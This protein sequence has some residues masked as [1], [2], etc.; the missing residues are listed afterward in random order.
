MAFQSVK[1]FKD[2]LPPES[3]AMTSL[4]LAARDVLR[5]FGYR[6]IRIPTLE[7]RELFVKS[8]GETT[9]IVEK[10]M[11]QLEDAGGRHLVLRPEG[12]AGV[13][14]AYLEHSLSQ[15]G[16]RTKLFYIGSMF[17]A[18]RPQKGRFREFEQIGLECFGNGHAAGDVEAILALSYVLD[19]AGLKGA[20]SIKLNNLGDEKPECRPAYRASLLAFFETVKD[21]LCEHCR[22]RMARNPLRVL[23]CKGDGPKLKANPALPTLVPC[24]DCRTHFDTVK[25][26]LENE[27]VAYE[28]DGSLVRGLDY[29]TR[30]VFEFR[31]TDVGAQDAI[32]GGGRYDGLVKAMGGP[33]TPAVG[34]AIGVERTRLAIAAKAHAEAPRGVDVYVAAQS[35]AAGLVGL[36]MGLLQSLRRQGRSAEGALFGHSLKAQLREADRLGARLAVIFGQEEFAGR[37][38][39]LKDMRVKDSQEVVAIADVLEKLNR[40][41][42]AMS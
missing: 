6:E 32:A 22:S 33:E 42:G 27:S 10:E 19:R 40:T 41:L 17:R 15:Q 1:G 8:V 4:E 31:S 34:W 5:A 26:L 29:Y 7:T 25:A 13:V 24:G 3:E 39:L 9:D 38:C 35:D 36:A 20:Y 14:R 28:L 2:I 12:T 16:G 11:F 37:T 18:E 30:T 21:E 23:D